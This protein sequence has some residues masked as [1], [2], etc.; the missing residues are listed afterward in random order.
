MKSTALRFGESTKYWLTLF[1]GITT[2]SLTVCGMAAGM[3]W[4][5]YVGVIAGAAQLSWQVKTVNLDDRN[6]CMA[7]FVSN[8]HFGAIIFAGAL[9]S[10]VL[11]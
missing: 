1:S 11:S 8:K 5:F 7:K 9:A 3:S 4:P 10:N 6:D 2:A